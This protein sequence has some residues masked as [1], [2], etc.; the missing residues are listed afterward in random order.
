MM[1]YVLKMAGGNVKNTWFVV[2]GLKHVKPPLWSFNKEQ[3]VL[4]FVFRRKKMCTTDVIH[5]L[6][7]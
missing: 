4:H 3:L 1:Q 7:H 5:G 2:N 6:F